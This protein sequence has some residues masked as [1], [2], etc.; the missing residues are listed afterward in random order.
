MN[1]KSSYIGNKVVIISFNQ[2]YKIFHAKP[3]S[4]FHLQ[5]LQKLRYFSKIFKEF[6]L[7]S[8]KFDKSQEM[9]GMVNIPI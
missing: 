4:D 5:V 7:L 8:V 2:K 9:L 6:L 1:T 3:K